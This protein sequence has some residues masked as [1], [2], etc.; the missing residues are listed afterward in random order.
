MARSHLMAFAAVRP[1]KGVK[2]YSPTPANCEAYAKEMAE[3][4]DIEVTPCGSA[5]EVVT[6]TDILSTCTN[7]V[8]PTSSRF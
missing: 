5:A 2:V 8:K 1:I 6:G 3:L 7:S 4:L